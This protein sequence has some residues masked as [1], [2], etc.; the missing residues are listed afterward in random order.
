L[1]RLYFVSDV[2][3]NKCMEQ[4]SRNT[5][6]RNSK[7][8]EKNLAHYHFVHHKSHM[9]WPRKERG[10]PHWEDCDS[11]S[12]T[13]YYLHYSVNRKRDKTYVFQL[14]WP[15]YVSMPLPSPD[16][17]VPP[18]FSV[19]HVTHSNL[20]YNFLEGFFFL[21]NSRGTK[22]YEIDSTGRRAWE[23]KLRENT[24]TEGRNTNKM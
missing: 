14:C 12:E 15:W 19:L 10:S 17:S 6:K 1:L 13:W 9:N 8:S 2:R 7:Y 3:M 20:F 21:G 5:D 23:K 22:M 11:L 18:P 24:I 16:V 4:C